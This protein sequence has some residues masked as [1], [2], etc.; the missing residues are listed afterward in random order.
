MLVKEQDLDKCGYD[1][2]STEPHVFLVLTPQEACE[3]IQE[4]GTQMA[5][6]KTG[7]S[8]HLWQAT[9]SI[10]EASSQKCRFGVSITDTGDIL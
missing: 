1:G 2:M 8:I 6:L 7:G 3:L 5:T 9:K 10:A 4:L